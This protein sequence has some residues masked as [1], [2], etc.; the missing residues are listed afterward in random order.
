LGQAWAE[1]KGKLATSRHLIR[2]KN[3]V[4][5]E[6]KVELLMQKHKTEKQKPS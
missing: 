2:A 4:E 1:G 6:V 5:V 3:Q